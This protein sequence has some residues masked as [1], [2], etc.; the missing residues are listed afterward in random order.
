MIFEL[1]SEFPRR[2]FLPLGYDL[3]ILLAYIKDWFLPLVQFY[4]S[5][6]LQIEMGSCDACEFSSLLPFH[7]IY[8]IL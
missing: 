3:T 8:A 5:F 1:N 6:R 7:L 2:S 4:R